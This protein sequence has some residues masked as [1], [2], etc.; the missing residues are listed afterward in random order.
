ML[1]ADSE[2][3]YEAVFMH[4]GTEEQIEARCDEDLGHPGDHI[5]NEHGYEWPRED[6]R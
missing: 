5:D 6:S 4:P 2:C 1:I 3:G